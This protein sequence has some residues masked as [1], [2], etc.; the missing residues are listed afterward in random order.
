MHH[1][2]ARLAL[3]IA[4][5]S[6]LT[7]ALATASQ[8]S[9]A[10]TSLVLGTDGARYEWQGEWGALPGGVALG[11]THGRVA[12]DAL[13]NV[14]VQTDTERAV[15]VFDADGK[16]LRSFGSGLAGGLHG[17]A[18]VREGEEEFLYMTH[19]GQGRVLKTTL[20]GRE[21][22]S[23]GWPEESGLYESA[24]QY[25]PTSVAVAP[26]GDLYVAD[27]YGLSWIHRYDRERKYLGS[28]GGPGEEPGK[29]RTPHGI[30]MQS[31]GD[32]P[33]LL[34]ADRENHRV[35]SFDLEGKFIELWDEGFRRP[36]YLADREGVLA[37]ADLDGGVTL[38]DA[39]GKPLAVL[40][41]NPD[42]TQRARNDLAPVDRTPGLFVSPHGLA[43][44][45]DGSLYVVE[46]LREGRVTKLVPVR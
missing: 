7:V 18:L 35:Q 14:Y 30:W 1:S 16:F 23:L 19:L 43:W 33:V 5:V 44:A 40:G 45:A 29:L 41:D 46:W 34:V 13:G 42:A 2:H 4:A 28:F 3:P 32:E 31:G 39:E 9:G 22:W 6:L 38:L 8:E 20:A 11:S 27:G 15:C 36:C 37:L 17:M 21:L 25:R 26:N 24:D 10:Q 12:V